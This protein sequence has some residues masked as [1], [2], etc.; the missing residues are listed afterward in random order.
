MCDDG[1]QFCSNCKREVPRSNFVMHNVHCQRKLALCNKCDEPVP[2]CELSAHN[3]N[4]HAVVKCPACGHQCEKIHLVDHQNSSCSHR[5]ICCNYCHIEIEA[6]ELAEHENYCGSR[7]ERCEDCGEFV[8]LKYQQLHQDSNHSFLKLKDEPGPKPSWSNMRVT[9]SSLLNDLG[10]QRKVSNA[11]QDSARPTS[12]S[13]RLSPSKRTNDMPQVNSATTAAP[14]KDHHKTTIPS[15]D[16]GVDLDQLLALRL[17]EQEHMLNTIPSAPYV[18]DVGALTQGGGELVALP[19][20]FCQAMVPANQLVIHE[21]GCR[22]DLARYDPVPVPLKHRKPSTS[23][24]EDKDSDG[25]PCEFCGLLFL[26]QFLLQHQALCNVTPPLHDG[27]L[28]N[29]LGPVPRSSSRTTK[30]LLNLA[31]DTPLTSIDHMED[32]NPYLNEMRAALK[33]PVA[34][35]QPIGHQYSSGSEFAQQK[36][37]ETVNCHSN[38]TS[39][40]C[41]NGMVRHPTSTGAVPKQKAG[42]RVN[43]RVYHTNPY[44]LFVYNWL[45]LAVVLFY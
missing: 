34:N 24:E 16:G 15:D 25:L 5:T 27:I 43:T 2:R 32:K 33:K 4:F 38:L 19:C 7:T 10:R 12:A 37:L 41:A 17:A 42:R 44:L 39:Q 1:V 11:S 9:S 36:E 20:E 40:G 31:P 13:N 21:T 29:E 45:C 14:T 30:K 28:V 35:V 6:N 22:P 26:P 8:M 18:V 3:T 23:S